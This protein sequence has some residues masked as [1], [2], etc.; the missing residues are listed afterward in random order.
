M[1][2]IPG[3]NPAQI[4][5]ENLHLISSLEFEEGVLDLA[6]GSGRNGLY[7]LNHNIP[8]T[9]ADNNRVCLEEIDRLCTDN[10]LAQTWLVD[11]EAEHSNPLAG[12]RFD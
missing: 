2:P 10:S 5:V 3:S 1:K 11:L 6:C 7:L 12:K 9:F 8:V 4:L